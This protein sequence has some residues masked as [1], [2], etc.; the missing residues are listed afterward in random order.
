MGSVLD[1]PNEKPVEEPA[2][3]EAA[4]PAATTAVAPKSKKPVGLIITFIL[5]CVAVAA[6][7][8]VLVIMLINR[9]SG[10]GGEPGNTVISGGNGGNGGNTGGGNTAPTTN[11]NPDIVSPSGA[12]GEIGD[13]VRGKVDSTVL[14]VEYA[15]MQ[16]PACASMMPK[17]NALYEKYGDQVA[18]VYRHFPITSHKNARAAALAVEAAGKQGYYWE[19]LSEVFSEQSS[20]GSATGSSLT[21]SFVKI[22]ESVAG[23]NGDTDQFKKDYLEDQ[24]LATKVDF[25][26]SLGTEAGLSA[27]PTVYVN[28]KKVDIYYIND[29]KEKIEAAIN[30]ALEV[31]KGF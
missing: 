9:P 19:M 12:N 17:M 29:A 31:D 10:D 22:F 25:D 5:I 16:C 14:V 13:H 4:A 27:T 1:L 8:V 6:L 23:N 18:F 11:I 20:W 28:G 30:D 21:N 3:K 26:K 7:T 15:D 2:K 24:N